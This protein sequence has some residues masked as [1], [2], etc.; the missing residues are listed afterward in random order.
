[1]SN[2][3]YKHHSST[4]NGIHFTEYTALLTYKQ[5]VQIVRRNVPYPS[6]KRI[7]P[8]RKKIRSL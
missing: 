6:T 4:Y 2:T 7:P 8:K 3:S 1:M 5:Y